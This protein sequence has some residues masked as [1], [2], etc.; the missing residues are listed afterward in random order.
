MYK[1]ITL[2]L[3]LFSVSLNSCAPKKDIYAQKRVPSKNQEYI[4]Q[5]SESTPVVISP[6]SSGQNAYVRNTNPTLKND[7][8]YNYLFDEKKEQVRTAPV[9]DDVAN[10]NINKLKA[11]TLRQYGNPAQ[12]NQPIRQSALPKKSAND[13]VFFIQV[14]AFSKRSNAE[15]VKSKLNGVGNIVIENFSKGTKELNRVKVGPISS[16]VSA[17]DIQRRLEKRGFSKTLILQGE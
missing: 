6:T 7:T 2:S 1:I 4:Q 16:L 9:I 15:K 8:F 17:I 14:G 10:N 3:V 11:D 12:A 13:Q 5:Q